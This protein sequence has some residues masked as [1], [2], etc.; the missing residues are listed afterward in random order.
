MDGTQNYNSDRSPG[1]R[2]CMFSQRHLQRHVSRCAE[3]EFEDVICEIDEVEL[4]VPE[5]SRLFAV[6]QKIANRLAR[7]FA[8]A[9]ANPCIRKLRLKR[10]Y[11]LFVA[12]CQAPSDLL[13][14]DAIEV[15]RQNCSKSVCWLPEVWPG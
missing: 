1:P 2:I 10:K 5:P 9:L 15:W 7:H 3:Y 12:I 8:V 4:L 6:G 13:S 11:D 14:L